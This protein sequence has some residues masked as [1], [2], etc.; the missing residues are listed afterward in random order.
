MFTTVTIAIGT[1]ITIAT[2]MNGVFQYRRTVH[3]EIFRTYAHKYNSI[4]VPS[5]YEKWQKALAGNKQLWEEMTPV[6]VQYLNLVCRAS[7]PARIAMQNAARQ[8]ESFAGSSEI[9]SEWG[10]ETPVPRVPL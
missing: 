10:V 1:T 6:M 8:S 3:M 5:H 7:R 9:V 2:F 4:V